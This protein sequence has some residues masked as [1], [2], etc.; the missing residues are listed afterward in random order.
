MFTKH[1]HDILVYAS[2]STPSR[3]RLCQIGI[4]ANWNEIELL[5]HV[6]GYTFLGDLRSVAELYQLPF[7]NA[8]CRC[9]ID[10]VHMLDLGF[11]ERSR[12]RTYRGHPAI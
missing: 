6:Y 7:T 12:A 2:G 1:F 9:D 3:T 8:T 11:Y 10:Y 4:A 5:L